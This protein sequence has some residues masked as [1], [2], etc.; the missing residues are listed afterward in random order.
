[1]AFGI[2]NNNQ[3]KGLWKWALVSYPGPAHQE[4]GYEAKWPQSTKLL[5]EFNYNW[6]FTK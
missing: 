1:M 3:L 5:S 2:L 6:T 4:P